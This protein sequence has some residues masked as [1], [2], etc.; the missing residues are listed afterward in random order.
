MDLAYWFA[1]ALGPTP[2]LPRSLESVQQRARLV[3]EIDGPF[4]TGSSFEECVVNI[5]MRIKEISSKSASY[6]PDV[7]DN[8]TRM[9]LGLRLWAGCLS[10]A[11]TIALETMD[12]PNS[13]EDRARIFPSIDSLAESDPI[14]RAGVEAAPEF[15]R[16]RDDAY[17]FEGVPANSPVRRYER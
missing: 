6:M 2:G 4:I 7:S 1:Q 17:S 16:L 8:L 15:K 14:Y 12:G 9:N 3:A 5:G 13:P 11:K 10:A